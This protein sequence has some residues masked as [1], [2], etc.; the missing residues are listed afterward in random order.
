MNGSV[1]ARSGEATLKFDE[2]TQHNNRL[3]AQ[4]WETVLVLE[5]DNNQPQ[6]PT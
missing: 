5:T 1:A 4:E 2:V 6:P 3:K